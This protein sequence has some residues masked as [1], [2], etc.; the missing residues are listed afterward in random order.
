MRAAVIPG[1][2]ARWEIREV[3]TPRPGPGEVLIRV[4]ACGVCYND[5]LTT[6]AVIPFPSVSP[7]ITGHEPAGEIVELGPGVT[8]RRVGDLVGT[9]WIRG[10]CGRCEYCRRQVPVS[11]TACLGCAAPT[12]TGFTVQGGHAEFMVA[13]ADETTPLPEGLAPELAAPVLC[14][15]YTSWCAL[16]A[17]E[18]GPGERVAVL[19]IGGLGHLALQFSR[20]CGF[21]TVAITRT[22]DKHDLAR[23]LGADFVVAGGEELAAA[24]GADVILATGRSYPAAAEALRGLRPEGRLVLAGMD[25]SGSFTIAPDHPFFVQRQ[26]VIGSTHNGPQYLQEAL[27]LVA[28][29]KVTPMVE[30]FTMAEIP[31]V[32]DR[33]ARG[34]VRF[35]AVITY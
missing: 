21:E 6:K 22:E 26:R 1:V 9:T 31:D 3:P 11:G 29:G 35:R 28:S 8:S 4:R 18:P 27:A 24:G 10:T 17:A 15:G 32:I 20:A 2:N 19:G 13:A 12:A 34:D 25:T 7:A 30:V 16:R 5:V 14:A 23:K 33:V